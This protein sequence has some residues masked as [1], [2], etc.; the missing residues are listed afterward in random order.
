MNI[1]QS[2][3]SLDAKTGQR[4]RAARLCDVRLMTGNAIALD[5]WKLVDS[6][7]FSDQVDTIISK[8]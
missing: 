1:D 8:N 5:R 2:T 3:L 6:K 7:A 4:N